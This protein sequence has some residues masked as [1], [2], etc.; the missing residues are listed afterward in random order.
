V[1]VVRPGL[2]EAAEA[3]GHDW[4]V[5]R[6][7]E[8][9]GKVRMCG[10]TARRPLGSAVWLYRLVDVGLLALPDVQVP[11]ELLGRDPGAPQ[12]RLFKGSALAWR[13]LRCNP[14]SHGGVDYHRDALQ[15]PLAARERRPL[16]AR[17]LP[18]RRRRHVAW[19][20]VGTTLVVRILLVPL[21]VR[22]IHSMQSL[23]KHA[24]EMKEIQ[25]KYKGDRQR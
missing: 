8:V 4:L 22:Q 16:A 17:A 19:A 10:S 6:V 24:P 5:E 14:W 20:I 12:A 7:D 11:P 25:R 1:L 13:L 2:P 18:L 3:R 21:T 9:L 15:H 23:Q